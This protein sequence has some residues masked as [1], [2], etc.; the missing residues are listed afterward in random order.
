MT[1]LLYTQKE[2]SQVVVSESDAGARILYCGS[3]Q[4]PYILYIMY[5]YPSI[6]SILICM[7][8]KGTSQL[9]TAEHVY[10]G[11]WGEKGL[12]DREKV[13]LGSNV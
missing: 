12:T 7:D 3:I 1:V 2:A 4:D 5:Y 13:F 8:S 10:L 6:G 9:L 11:R